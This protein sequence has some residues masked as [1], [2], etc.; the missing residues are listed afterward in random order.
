MSSSTTSNNRISVQQQQQQLP[1]LNNQSFYFKNGDDSKI[2]FE[3]MPDQYYVQ[4]PLNNYTSSSPSKYV[5]TVF[6]GKKW[7]DSFKS[8][9]KNFGTKELRKLIID[10]TMV[11]C[12]QGWY[13]LNKTSKIEFNLDL[14]HEN[15][16]KTK[17]HF[18]QPPIDNLKSPV[19]D[20]SEIKIYNEDCILVGKELIN[21]GF[22]P[23]VLNM[24]SKNNPGGGYL[25]GSGAQE[26]NLHRRTNLFCSLE[27]PDGI[28]RGSEKR[29][30]IPDHGAL[31]SP[32]I[33]VFRDSEMKGYQLLEEPYLMSFISAA[34]IPHP[35]C[36][37]DQSGRFMIKPDIVATLIKKIETI[38]AVALHHGH[39]SIVLSAFGCGAFK[40]PPHHM[41]QLFNQVINSNQFRNRFK[42][43]TFAIIED[44]NSNQHKEGNLL[45]FLKEFNLSANK[46]F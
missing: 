2:I 21:Q 24:A 25:K 4:P 42:L 8:R 12:R 10:Q 26:E 36:Y 46:L 7:L 39:D 16:R 31:Y 5:N 34:A 35:P 40:S 30:P 9:N 41:A 6:N 33:V 32:G 44:H 11:Y 20:H 17:V 29:Y 15:I 37:R 27:D 23:V 18:Q 45:P 14:L 13:P 3:D 1:Q 28:Q 43:V 19:L 22:N 38:L